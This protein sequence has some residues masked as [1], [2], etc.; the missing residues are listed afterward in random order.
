MTTKLSYAFLSC[1]NWDVLERTLNSALKLKHTQGE[2]QWVVVDNSTGEFQEQMKDDISYWLRHNDP[3]NSLAI[4]NGENVGEGAGMNMLFNK[5]VGENI[6]FF[7]DDWECVVDYNF[8]DLGI[9]V[10]D[11]FSDIF[12][13]QL[14]KRPWSPTNPNIKMGRMLMMDGDHAVAQMY[15]NGF[16]NNTFQVKLLKKAVWEK[17]GPYPTKDTIDFSKYPPGTREGS[18]GEFEYGKRLHELGYGA[19][20][21]NDGQFIHILEENARDEYFIKND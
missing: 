1:N 18:V 12:M 11:T 6:L 9:K 20:K 4:C 19:A 7:Q 5:C 10:L 8:I 21:I 17:V 3:G 2:A 15:P 13:L 14:S 16:G